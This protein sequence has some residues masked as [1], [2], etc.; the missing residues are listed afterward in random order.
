MVKRLSHYLLACF[1]WYCELVLGA[2]E[3]IVVMLCWT[4]RGNTDVVKRFSNVWPNSQTMDAVT[5]TSSD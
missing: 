1:V 5:T 4:T 3:G 2:H